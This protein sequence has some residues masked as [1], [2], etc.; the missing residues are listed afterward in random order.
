MIKCII[1]E[2]EVLAQQ[3]IQSHLQ[4]VDRFQLVGVCSNTKEAQVLLDNNEV[5]VMFL[6][7]QLPGITGLSFL[8]MLQDPPLVVLTTA[9]AEYALESYDFNV[10]DYLLKPISLERFLKTINKIVDGKFLEEKPASTIN[11][12]EHIFIKSSSR[13]YKIDFSNIIYVEGM[14]DYVKIHTHDNML[15]THQTMQ[16]MEQLLHPQKFMRI[17]KSYIVALNQIKSIFG[18]SIDVGKATLPIGINYKEKVMG[19][20]GM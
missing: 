4:K 20:V 1:V 17:H 9:Y 18:N 12:A 14:K 16:D 6:D 8:K 5:D 3:V 10:V 2:D 7:I 19:F 15:V 13:F 11:N